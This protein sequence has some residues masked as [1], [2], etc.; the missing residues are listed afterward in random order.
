MKHFIRI[1]TD[2][3]DF[4]FWSS[5]K[6]LSRCCFVCWFSVT[7]C[8]VVL[9]YFGGVLNHTSELW[10]KVGGFIDGRY[11]LGSSAGALSLFHGWQWSSCRYHIQ[12]RNNNHE[13]MKPNK[14][15]VRKPRVW[16]CVSAEHTYIWS[17]NAP[18][19]LR[20][21]PLG[22]HQTSQS[23]GSTC[24]PLFDFTCPNNTKRLLCHCLQ[25][26]TQMYTVNLM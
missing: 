20:G 15:L 12:T 1:Q 2:F 24:P 10:A 26:V 14:G 13:H 6:A 3:S 8:L 17:N 19:I 16:V 7:H 22:K 9:R 18:W 11:T 5:T 21:E 23:L 4:S 25:Q